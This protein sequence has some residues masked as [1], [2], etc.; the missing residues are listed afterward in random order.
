MVSI[1]Q[2]DLREGV[3]PQVAMRFAFHAS[4]RSHGHEDGRG[5]LAVGRVEG[6]G[7]RVRCG[8]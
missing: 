1:S 2:Y 7:A 4:E 3:V 6:A 5:H 8:V